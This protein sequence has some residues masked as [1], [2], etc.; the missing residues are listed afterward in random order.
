[1][2]KVLDRLKALV[3]VA[4][5]PEAASAALQ[6]ALGSAQEERDLAAANLTTATARYEQ[7]LLD[8][9]QINQEAFAAIAPARVALDRAELLVKTLNARLAE[10][11]E[12]E[13]AEILDAEHAA[14]VA[15]SDAVE[16]QLR[17]R[18]GP[19]TTELA[20]LLGRLQAVDAARLAIAE[21]LTAAGREAEPVA[22]L[23]FRALPREYGDASIL[24]DI[25]LPPVAG[26]SPGW[27][28]PI[29]RFHE[30][31]AENYPPRTERTPQ[32]PRDFYAVPA[33]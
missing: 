12:R 33:S 25:V 9:L 14:V 24:T 17:T 4:R 29:R 20:A 23:E 7:T 21:K 27:N 19:L 16:H 30:I 8:D 5:E 26:F 13:A 11:I 6:G 28:F 10:A 3:A 1:M 22:P 15:E 2:K 18:F 31:P 32:S